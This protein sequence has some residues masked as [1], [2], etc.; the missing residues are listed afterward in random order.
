SRRRRPDAFRA[1]VA[2]GA[3]ASRSTRKG[4][5]TRTFPAMKYASALKNLRIGQRIWLSV[6]LLG[7]ALVAI[8]ASAAM[9]AVAVKNEQAALVPAQST[10]VQLANQWISLTQLNAERTVATLAASDNSVGD[11][12]KAQVAKT[13]EEISGIQKQIDAL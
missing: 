6:A 12:M 4:F 9:R 2:D 13:S 1:G 8:L 10:K 5:A 7:L 3:P 11:F